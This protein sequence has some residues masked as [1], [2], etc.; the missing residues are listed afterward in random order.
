MRMVPDSPDHPSAEQMRG[1]EQYVSGLDLPAEI[2][3]GMNDPILGQALGAMK[4][5]FPNASVLET[6]GGHFLQEEV[7]EEIAAAILRVLAEVH[8]GTIEDDVVTD[9]LEAG[10]Q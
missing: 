8:A 4:Q 3:W 9:T 6:E 10:D 7:P 1:I 2:V 5:S